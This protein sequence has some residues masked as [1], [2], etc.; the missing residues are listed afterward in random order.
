MSKSIVISEMIPELFNPGAGVL[1][2]HVPDEYNFSSQLLED[3]VKRSVPVGESFGRICPQL[4]ER[5]RTL[6]FSS[7]RVGVEKL[8]EAWNSRCGSKE[9]AP[10]VNHAYMDRFFRRVGIDKQRALSELGVAHAGD[11]ID[12]GITPRGGRKL[13]ITTYENKHAD[14][15]EFLQK[16]EYPAACTQE[17]SLPILVDAV[18]L[19]AMA[20]MNRMVIYWQICEACGWMKLH[21][22]ENFLETWMS[23]VDLAS[24]ELYRHEVR[25]G[26]KEPF[27]LPYQKDSWVVCQSENKEPISW[28]VAWDQKEILATVRNHIEIKVSV[29]CMPLEYCWEAEYNRDYRDYR[30]YSGYSSYRG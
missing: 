12:L 4:S 5:A 26:E 15:I 10:V 28:K 6:V 2:V 29:T 16:T 21:A 3:A 19:S 25:V 18:I 30:G 11:T 8:Y 13:V 1:C 27:L 7:V 9:K 23:G 17:E 14:Y 20:H 22:E 24:L